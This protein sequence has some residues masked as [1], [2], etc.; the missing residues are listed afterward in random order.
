MTQNELLLRIKERLQELYGA[1]FRGLVLYG[2]VARGD[3][4]EDS[5][6]D[7]LCL[8]EG[9]VETIRETLCV[10]GELYPLQMEYLNTPISV[11]VV[12]TND[13]EEGSYPLVIEA[14]KEGV[15]I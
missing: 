3:V 7:L 14:K 9:P 8:L 5:D 13:Y 11:K 10:I 12:D 1:R 15:A 4:G 2:S 6:L